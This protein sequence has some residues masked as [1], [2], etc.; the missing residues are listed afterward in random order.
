M[1]EV[2]TKKVLIFSF[3]Y[4]P[5][6]GGAEVALREITDRIGGFE[7]DLITAKISQDLPNF[8]KIGNIAVYRVGQGNKLD[9]PFYPIRAFL[10]SRKLHKKNQYSLVW[11]MMASWAGIAVLLFKLLNPRVKYLLT[12]QEGD[13]EEFLRKRTWFWRPFYE[14][15]YK[16]ADHI[17][18]ISRWLEQRAKDY[19]YKGDVSV[20]P[21]GVDLEKFKIQNSKF[22]IKREL[23]IKDNTKIIFTASRLVEKNDI[24]TLIR[25]FKILVSDILISSFLIIAGGGGLEDKLK[26]LVLGLG[27]QD[28]VF[29]L[30]QLSPDEA[31]KYYSIADIFV[32]PSLSEGFGNS[33]I[34]AMAASL[35]IVATPVGGILDFLEDRKTGLF[36]RVKDPRD[37]ADKIKMIFENKELCRTIRENG[38]RLAREKYDWNMIAEKIKTII[39]ELI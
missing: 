36:C 38:L 35:P 12:L 30:G 13:S 20:V 19:G 21:N 6:A 4:F 18:A 14:L 24:E 7:F 26:K 32:R 27:I 28:K 1:T 5:F 9:K 23:N 25:A 33:F 37:L 11:A 17:Q 39:V 3:T 22:K 16:K 34:E 29:F 10:F 8:E 2:K 31:W 15:I